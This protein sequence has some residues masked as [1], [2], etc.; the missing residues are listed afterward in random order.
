MRKLNIGTEKYTQVFAVDEK[1]FNANH[2]Y[3]VITRS[4]PPQLLTAIH[5]QEGPI[6][7]NGVN[8][9]KHEITRRENA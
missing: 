7:E 2:H 5:F 1:G 4:E 3:N 8:G 9:C 6:K